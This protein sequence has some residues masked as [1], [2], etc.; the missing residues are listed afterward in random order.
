MAHC[1]FQTSIYAKL[2]G[3]TAT[4]QPRRPS[5]AIS[6]RILARQLDLSRPLKIVPFEGT[7]LRKEALEAAM[8]KARGRVSIVRA[9]ALTRPSL[10]LVRCWFVAP[11]IKNLA[12]FKTMTIIKESLTTF[13]IQPTTFQ[14]PHLLTAGNFLLFG[15]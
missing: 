6:A 1:T 10:H 15:S 8:V 2:A 9:R 3:H 5:P 14:D 4:V 13:P 11:L 12:Q 7:H